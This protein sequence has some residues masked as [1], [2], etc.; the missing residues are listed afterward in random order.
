MTQQDKMK[1][2]REMVLFLALRYDGG[3]RIQVFNQYFGLRQTDNKTLE[4]YKHD[5]N[6]CICNN[7]HVHM[8]RHG[9]F[10]CEGDSIRFY[11]SEGM[12]YL[13]ESPNPTNQTRQYLF[14]MLKLYDDLT[15]YFDLFFTDPDE[16]DED[17][18]F[19]DENKN[20]I[21]ID[22]DTVERLYQ[23]SG[24]NQP[25]DKSST[26]MYLT[27]IFESLAIARELNICAW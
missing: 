7:I 12:E 21:Q 26:E 3:I 15:F 25:L 27:I 24:I 9:E 16:Y 10:T 11:Y 5:I 1:L 2:T 22:S 4:R 14:H 13:K 23:D 8:D 20:I 17:D 6:A 18:E 19:I